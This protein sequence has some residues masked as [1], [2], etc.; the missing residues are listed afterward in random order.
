MRFKAHDR[1]IDLLVG[2]QLYSTADAAIRELLQNAEDACVLQK[3]KN[4][5][6]TES[7]II[8]Y[9]IN[10]NFIEVEDNGLGMNDDAI[11]NGF[12]SIAAPKNDV[13]HIHELMAK[14]GS[15]QIAQFGIGVLSCFGVADEIIVLTKMDDDKGLAFKINDYHDDFEKLDK[16]PDNRGTII[17]LNLKENGPM[18]SGQTVEAVKKYVRHAKHVKLENYDTREQILIDD[19]WL[20]GL[21]EDNLNIKDTSVAKGILI[22]DSGWSNLQESIKSNILLCNGGFL[23]NEGIVDLLPNQAVGYQGELDI[24]PGELTILINREG[25]KRDGKWSGLGSRLNKQFNN[26]IREQLSV[27]ESDVLNKSHKIDINAIERGILVLIRSETK[28]I[29]E[30]DIIV[31]LNGLVANVIRLNVFER[32]NPI[33]ITKI[34]ESSLDKGVIYYTRK[35]EE[36]KQLKKDLK[37]G[38]SSVQ[39]IE[40]TQT[41]KFRAR[42]LHLKGY[43]VV[44][45]GQRSYRVERGTSAS[46]INLH[47]FDIFNEECQKKGIKLVAVSDAPSEH[48]EFGARDE[49]Q[50]L[51]GLLGLGE[52]FNLAVFES[53]TD[54]VVRDYAGRLLNCR[55]P[56]VKEIL[57]AL[58]A[59]VGNPIKKKLLQIY[60]DINNYDLSQA[61]FKVKELLT[62]DNLHE[63][64]QLSTGV[65]LQDYLTNKLKKLFEE[66]DEEV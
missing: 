26:L 12:S 66:E 11:E 47:E 49:S 22:L 40:H 50:I 35:G 25:F 5:E 28:N 55:H 16:L 38:T 15:A 23:I 46:N 31:K 51:S 32:D 20:L 19:N 30:S 13:Q 24:K 65:L 8:K 27:W 29:L 33:P 45:C 41:E 10:E 64:A 53:D 3:I 56:E 6:Y 62:A 60:L 42:L 59:V 36:Q 37:Q 9:S 58:P 4:P 43:S 54:R 18:T 17:R 48:I 63:D 57:K 14:A 39:V 52:Q 61:Q 21:S 2:E 1:V 7:I 44:S 34:L